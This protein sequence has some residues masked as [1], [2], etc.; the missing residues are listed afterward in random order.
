MKNLA[1]LLA[2]AFVAAAF[3]AC[4]G[5]DF[6]DAPPELGRGPLLQYQVTNHGENPTVLIIEQNGDTEL[7][8]NGKRTKFRL[9]VDE[10]KRL[11]DA[12]VRADFDN[13]DDLY[14]PREVQGGGVTR[15]R[16]QDHHLIIVK[17]ATIPP[18]LAAVRDRA[19]QIASKHGPAPTPPEHLLVYSFSG[20]EEGTN[21]T[22]FIRPNGAVRVVINGRTWTTKLS[23]RELARWREIID[24]AGIEALPPV[25][26]NE[27]F[28]AD[29]VTRTVIA[30]GR[31]VKVE[32]ITKAPERLRLL[33]TQ[34]DRILVRYG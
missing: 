6:D 30:D 12:V 25:Y 8:M 17:G 1:A 22:L 9:P 29:G 20:G 3:S 11:R 13:L 23:E 28:V 2:V 19:M 31:T 7:R 5:V 18:N 33:M 34:G 32:D 15:I 16:S 24:A 4:G 21:E 10:L 27:G 14:R 26:P